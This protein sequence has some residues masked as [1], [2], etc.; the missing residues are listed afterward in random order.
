[1]AISVISVSS[2][3]SK[4]SV[5]RSTGRFILF[6][7]IPTTIPDTTPS[8]I[9]PSTHID[10]A[11]TPT[12]PDYSPASPVYSPASDTESDP[13]EDPSSDHIPPL[14]LFHQSYHRL[15]ILQMS[16]PVT[17][18]ALRRRVMILAP[19]QPISHGL[20]YRYHPNGPIHMMTVRKRIGPLPTHCLAVR[21][22]VDYS[23]SDHFASND[24]LR[25][26]S[27]SSSSKTSSDP[28]SDDLSDSSS[29]HSLPT[30]SSGMR[31]S[32][33]LC[34]LV[35]SI[36]L[37]YVAI[38]DRPSHDSSS[39]SPS[40]KRSRSHVA[41]VSLSLPITGALSSAC[42]DLLPSP[43]RIRSLESTTDLEVSSTEDSEP[44][45]YR[46]TDLKM[47]DDVERS[48]G[49]DIDPEIQ[50]E[51][52]EC[53]AYADSLRV[54]GI[55]AR[56]VVKAVDREEI[57]TG[58]RGPVEVRVDRVT[59]PVIVDDIPEPA[60][61]EGPVEVTYE[62]LGDLV[63][64]FHGHTE[65]ILVH[66][67]Q[68]ID[69]VE[70]DQGHMIVATRTREGV[71]EQIYHRLVGVLRARDTAKN[72]E[73]LI[74]GGGER[75][76]V[77][78][79]EGNENEGNRNRG[80]GNGG[81]GNGGGNGYNFGGFMPA[82]ECTYQDF[83]KYQ[84]LS[85]NGKEGVVGLTRWFEKMETMFHISNYLEKYQ[86]KMVPYED[87]KVK[88]FVGGLPDNIQGNVIAA[89]PTKL[90]DAICIANNLMDQKLKGYARSAENK[91]R[92]EN[93]PRDN[94]RQQPVFKRQTVGGQNLARAYTARNNKKKGYVGSLPYSNKCKL[95]HAG[96]CTVTCGNCKRVGH[97]T[98]DCKVTITPN[99]QRAPVGNQPGIVC[100]KCGRSGYFKKDCSK[101]RNHNHGNKTRNKSG[102]KTENQTGGNEATTRDYTIRGGGANPDS[103]F[104][105]G[106][107]LVN[108]CYASMLFDSGTDRSFVSSTVSALLDVA[109]STLN[110]SYAVELV[111]ERISE[112]NVVLRCCTLGL[113][114][115][116]FDIDLMPVELVSK[117]TEDKSE[118]KRLED[119]PIIRELPEFFPEDFL[120]LPPARQVEFQFDLV[121]GAAPI[122]RASYRLAPTEMQELSTQL[123]ELS[124][125][126]LIR[127]I[128][129]PWGAPV[130]FVKKKDGSFWM[131]IDYRELNKLTA[132]DEVDSKSMKFDWGE[133]AEAVFQL[134][135][136][137]LC[138]AP[139]LALPE[140]S[141]NF[142]KSLNKALG[143]RLD[144]STTYRPQTDGQSE[145]TIQTL[146]DMLRA[147]ALDFG[148]GPFK[149]I[150]KVGT[151]AYRL[152]LPEQLS[153]VH[154]TFHVSNLKKCI[155]DKPLAIP[156]DEIQVDDKL[157]FI[158]EPIK[159][160]DRKVKRLKQS[161][162]LIVKI[163]W[164]SRRGPEFTWERE[165]Q[166]KKKYPHL[167]LI[168]A[169]VVDV[170]S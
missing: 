149:I 58:A 156:L 59:H 73:P 164:N 142:V 54:R 87:D 146:E 98:R 89:E 20:P 16:T 84:P 15:T 114:G 31:P 62:T 132:Y 144:M 168:F 30:P 85:F 32:H 76:E 2:D 105:M 38:S 9:P 45:R 50:A 25:D 65:E 36:P 41:S 6:G 125:K 80:N 56:V 131:C 33:H 122:A 23:S 72:L 49:I 111:D 3:S 26:S 75:E 7:T 148:K 134:L 130:L 92:F 154:S 140:G 126:G 94:R 112:T 88:R 21:H 95:H 14:Q 55:D 44:S 129:S 63:Q 167:F 24:S 118:E 8:V 27:S 35:P 47:D 109:P 39:A 43:K 18:G 48:D 71:N 51:I 165:D 157:H 19:G 74:G 115:H 34:S 124:K 139:I 106:T 138:S 119:V 102:N 103:N 68:A 70:R 123:Q 121:P 66:C 147:C 160:M 61:E 155:S 137:K 12:S 143:T 101:L 169:P 116:L 86:V 150:A 11:L 152:E 113:L 5:G 117:K 163:R 108:N 90:Q 57:E 158:E 13:F 100:Y 133:K 69:S 99:T 153:R 159:V 104:V 64:R 120:R 161:H 166:M 82:R 136:Q 42:A 60:Q 17:S 107:F 170:T 93:N 145:K 78:G 53:V 67:V 79:N 37:S 22:S 46:G 128:S 83:L 81:N 127:P 162:I 10:T 151:G 110:T 77:N 97:M 40:R 52:N 135:K 29:D 91:R 141:E 28:S 1:M 96:S 4:E